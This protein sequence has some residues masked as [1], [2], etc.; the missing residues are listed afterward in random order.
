ML[1]MCTALCPR[2]QVQPSALQVLLLRRCR[3]GSNSGH[4]LG[5]LLAAHM[6]LRVLD[7]SENRGLGT[8]VRAQ[9]WQAP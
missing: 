9:H 1:P 4:H 7:L 2:T 6:R 8:E 3:L 5:D